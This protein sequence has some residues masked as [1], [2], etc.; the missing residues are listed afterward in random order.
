MTVEKSALPGGADEEV[1]GLIATL[2]ATGLRLEELTGGEVDAVIGGDGATFVLQRAQTELRLREAARQAAILNAIP[3]NIAL[4]DHDGVILSVNRTWQ[5]FSDANGLLGPGHAAGVDYLDVC[6]N[7]R[8]AGS[9]DGG[10]AAD[11]IRSVL[12]GQATEFSMEYPCHSPT[13]QRWFLMTVTPLS[14]NEALGAVIRHLNMT[15][16]HMAKES[17]VASE[18]QFRQVADN[19]GDAFALRGLDGRVIYVNSA[20][21]AIWGRSR[22]SLYAK[23]DSWLESIHPD[24]LE[25]VIWRDPDGTMLPRF[26]LEF[27]ILHPD[28]SIRW[29][30]AKRYPVRNEAGE[31][32]RVATI[33]TNITQR[34]QSE[35]GITRLNRVYQV[36][37]DINALTVRVRDRNELF[38]EACRIAVD[39]GGFRMAMIGIVEGGTNKLLTVASAGIDEAMMTVIR[40]I[41]S[42]DEI[43]PANMAAKT[44]RSQ[45]PFVSNDLQG[46]SRVLLRESL[47][48]EG[49]RSLAILPLIV[50]SEPAGV[51]ILY[52]SEKDY[53]HEVEIT[54]LTGMAGDI[55][56]AITYVDRQERL[57]HFASYD[58]LTS[59]ANQRLLL[60]R[61]A[62]WTGAADARGNRL[63]LLLIDVE[64]FKNINDSLGRAAGDALLQQVA[65][66]LT[67]HVA[68]V[69]RVARIG[70]DHFAVVLSEEGPAGDA[71]R[72]IEA[73]IEAFGGHPFRINGDDYRIAAKFGV[74]IFPADGAD[75]HVLFKN[76][77]AALKKAKSSGHRLLFYTKKMTETVS[78]RLAFENQLQ[79]AL[80]ND[81]FVLHY[82]PKVNLASGEVTSVEALIRWNDPRTGLVPPGLFIPILEETGMIYEVGR[83]ALHRSL[84]DYRRWRNAGLRAV[85]IAVNVSPLQLRHPGFIDMIGQ[86]VATDAHAAQALELEITEGA[87]MDDMEQS[88]SSLR[89]IRALGISI[90]I[91]DFGTGFSSLGYLSKLPIDTLKIDRMFV[92]DM[93]ADSQGLALVSTIIDLAHAL[94]LKVV[95]EGVETEEQSKLLRLLKCDEMQGY[96]FSEPVPVGELERK[97]LTPPGDALGGSAVGG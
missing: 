15:S 95:A 2:H 90:A 16:E 45:L 81:E 3:V 46:D 21:E 89:A 6:E 43:A 25:S 41:L 71:V 18:L 93:V 28:G 73:M 50:A 79:H 69:K 58:E 86:I 33:A 57:D 91:D 75:A 7:A 19:I 42:T 88:S 48:A 87:I 22:A 5:E 11:G 38:R 13:Q 84:V 31:I 37:R 74:A 56:L 51:L 53:F 55:A 65:Q 47:T 30:E 82:Q 85:R 67:Q 12:S 17:L 9:T 80:D 83:W 1:A 72:Q 29:I 14:V 36:H 77:E 59:L 27:R 54:Q 94:Q 62:Q 64:R 97:Y 20:Y 63:A 68:D 26:E 66:W 76:A 35:L 10:L 92:T 32:V 96:I 49:V 44:V 40:N 4:L 70:A 78:Q 60:E 61:L 8:Q 24:D 52:S 39:I 34:K 23:H